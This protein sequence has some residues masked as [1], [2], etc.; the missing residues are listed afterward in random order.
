MN[1]KTFTA[2][3]DDKEVTFLVRSPTLD[4][5]RGAQKAYNQAFT[6]AIK[7]DSI[8]R[9]KL[10]DLLKEQGLWNDQKEAEFNTLQKEILDGEQRIA[11]GGFS[12]NE[13]KDLAIKIKEKREKI[14]E[15]ISVRTNLDTHTAEG[16][17]DN[18]RFNYL[19]SVCV[20]YNDSKQKYFDNLADYLQRST[21]P[22]ALNGAQ[23]LANMMYGLDSNYESNLPENKFLKKYKFIDQDLRFIDKQGRLIDQEGRLVDANG[24]FINEE[25]KYVD[26]YGK[27]INEDG[28]YI[29]DSQPFLDD[30]GNPIILDDE[31]SESTDEDSEST[32][33]D[34]ESENT[35]TSEDKEPEEK[36]S[37]SR[38]R[39]K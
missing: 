22:V 38:T 5:Q 4:D 16:Q 25:G 23:I 37:K 10:D 30:D 24:R 35:E 9:A 1:K 33:D 34:S 11:A 14:R 21:E 29:V 27:L 6:D 12:L 19:V 2:T 26:K 32:N 7:S 20:V 13:A 17:A 28:D 18:A 3:I 15:L 39:K 31:D 8:V 36:T